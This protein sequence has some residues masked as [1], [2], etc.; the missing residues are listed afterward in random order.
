MYRMP[1]PT[2]QRQSL[3]SNQVPPPDCVILFRSAVWP[4]PRQGTGARDPPC[5]KSYTLGGVNYAK[6]ERLRFRL[7][8]GPALVVRTSRLAVYRTGPVSGFA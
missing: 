2:F 3:L 5:R 1:R 6:K 4:P 7:A 8:A